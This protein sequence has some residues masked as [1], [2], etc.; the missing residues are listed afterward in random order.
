M[1]E[2]MQFPKTVE[3]FMK[4]YEIVDTE[5]VYTNGIE[6]VPIFRMDQWFEHNEGFWIKKKK[7]NASTCSKCGSKCLLNYE[8]DYFKSKFCPHCGVKMI[9]G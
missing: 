1:S 2:S 6:L 8:G 5:Q 3:E 9:N 4:Q 7:N